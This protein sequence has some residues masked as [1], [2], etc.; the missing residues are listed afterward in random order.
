M[1]KWLLAYVVYALALAGCTHFQ[2]SE[3]R[4]CAL[5]GF[6]SRV[7]RLPNPLLPNVFVV[8][9]KYLAVDQEP[10]LISGRELG[11]GGRLT[12]SW[13]LPA[14]TPYIFSTKAKN[15]PEG[16]VFSPADKSRGIEAPAGL[17][18]K[19][20]GVQEKVFQCSFTPAQRRAPPSRRA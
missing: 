7:V 11:R 4:Q 18:C 19:V 17:D 9:G 5:E 6:D 3:C 15:G 20:W 13:A 8:D 2:T 16:I 14:G 10:I 1:K 12:I